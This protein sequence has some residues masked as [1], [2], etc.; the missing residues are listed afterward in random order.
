MT[1]TIKNARFKT[2]NTRQLEMNRTAKRQKYVSK[3]I[4]SAKKQDL[5][6]LC[7]KG[8]IPKQHNVFFNSL[9]MATSGA[10]EDDTVASSDSDSGEDES[11]DAH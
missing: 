6:M 2:T 4:T 3:G 7:K 5:L 8:L 1:L 11:S 9:T 10:K